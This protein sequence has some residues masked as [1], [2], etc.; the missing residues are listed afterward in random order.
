MK[1]PCLV[2]DPQLHKFQRCMSQRQTAE[3]LWL[4]LLSL[5]LKHSFVLPLA[6]HLA[7]RLPLY[8]L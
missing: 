2:L 6:L 7:R 3:E 5:S 1:D 8:W 4:E